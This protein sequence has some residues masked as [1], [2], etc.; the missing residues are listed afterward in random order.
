M[1]EIIFWKDKEKTKIDPKLFSEEAEKFAKEIA[2]DNKISKNGKSNK[3]TQIRKFYDEVIRLDMEAKTRPQEWDNILPMLNMLTARAAYSKG[4]DE[5]I[6]DNFLT[7]IRSSINN[8]SEPKDLSV[9]ANFFEA[10]MG[11]Y[12]LHGPAK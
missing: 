10:F 7:F 11:F 6:S 5:L 4:R 1:S 8:V 2:E 9:F 3:R 12:K